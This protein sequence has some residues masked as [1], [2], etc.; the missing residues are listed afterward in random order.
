MN[1]ST[2][3]QAF[4]ANE[5]FEG[6]SWK[7]SPEPFS[8]TADQYE[9]IEAIG[10]ASVA[11]YHSIE[12]LYT[13]S[14]EN[15]SLLRNKTL[16]ASWVAPLYDA[17]KPRWLLDY[18]LGRT[19]KKRIPPIIR[20]DLL[21]TEEG[22]A[23]TE[24]D[25]VPG[26]IGLTAFL[27]EL[28]HAKQP[29]T[30]KEGMVLSFYNAVC[31]NAP[32]K[33]NPVIA[34]IVS[35]DAATYR[36]EFIWLADKLRALGKHAYCFH[37]DDIEHKDE[38]LIGKNSGQEIRIDIVYR[39]YELFELDDVSSALQIAKAEENGTITITP[40]MKPFQEEKLSFALFHHYELNEFFKEILTPR[41]YKLLNKIIPK[42][43]LLD[44]TP[45]TPNAILHAPMVEG[46]PT[47][48]WDALEQ[49][50]KKERDYIIKISGFHS[51]AWGA[52]G[53]TLGSDCSSEEWQAAMKVALMSFDQN[54]YII[55]EYK[56]PKQ[57]EHPLYRNDGT[58]SQESV[59]ARICPYYSV[60][61]SDSQVIGILS[62]L[63]PADKKIIHGM[64]DAALLPTKII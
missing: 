53:V 34:F 24:L 50:S 35:E 14:K 2:L 51:T 48:T 10:E 47:K 18:S 54:P 22:F 44:P 6:K 55:Q 40:P 32:P 26:G 63:C 1:S 31:A 64:S 39:F 20:P 37:P 8:L 36:P 21:L 33:D 58:L 4:S 23:L 17:G 46:R 29:I 11:F 16:L 45:V 49:A 57:I 38:F 12:K 62:T 41:H 27:N 5:L 60:K 15:K 25:S 28:Y 61:G 59:R 7:L 56:K 30:T 3:S 9:E 19:N 13:A 52:R 42:T 43:W